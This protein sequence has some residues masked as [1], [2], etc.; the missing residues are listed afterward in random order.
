MTTSQLD[1]G[2]QQLQLLINKNKIKEWPL[3]I[4]YW[5]YWTQGKSHTNSSMLPM[6]KSQY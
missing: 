3:L 1:I 4:L 2:L 6:S 5:L